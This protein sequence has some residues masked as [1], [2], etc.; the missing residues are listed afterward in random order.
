MPGNFERG[1]L[2]TIASAIGALGAQ[3]IDSQSSVAAIE[4]RQAVLN[5][6]SG[7]Y[8]ACMDVLEQCVT[9]ALVRPGNASDGE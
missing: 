1:I 9:G 5:N 6:C 2:L 8:S 7:S 3:Y 4:E